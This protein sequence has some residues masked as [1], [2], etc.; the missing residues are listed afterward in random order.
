MQT[1]AFRDFALGH[2]DDVVQ[3]LLIPGDDT[4]RQNQHVELQTYD[5]HIREYTFIEP[6]AT[7]VAAARHSA[8]CSSVSCKCSMGIARFLLN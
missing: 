5:R 4:V 6:L 1:L 8:I 7:S 2:C 3:K